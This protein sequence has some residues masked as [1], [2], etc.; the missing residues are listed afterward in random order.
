MA[1]IVDYEIKKNKKVYPIQADTHCLDTEP[2]RKFCDKIQDYISCVERANVL[3][4]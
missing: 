4:S 1:T 3:I 2:L